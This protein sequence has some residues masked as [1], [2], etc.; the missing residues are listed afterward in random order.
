RQRKTGPR[1]ARP[2]GAA[3]VRRLEPAEGDDEAM[4]RA[5]VLALASILAVAGPAPA[6]P[7]ITLT[8]PP[9]D[10]TGLLTLAVPPLE[11]PPVPVPAVSLPPIPQGMPELPPA[12]MVGHLGDRPVAPLPP[13]RFMAC[14]PV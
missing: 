2:E 9:P 6:L 14:H 5:G 3:E 12:P 8:L 7:E 11:K 10:V 4:I 13:P 1:A